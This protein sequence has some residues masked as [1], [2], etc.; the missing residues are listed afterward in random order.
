MGS[1]SQIERRRS[2]RFPLDSPVT[3]NTPDGVEHKCAARDISTGGIFFY[4]DGPF[5]QDSP[6]Q[7]VMILPAEITGGE[8][9]WAC[10]HGKVARVE[11]TPGGQRG[12]A[13]KIERIA[14]LPMA[15]A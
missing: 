4:C 1:T 7:L 9:Q 5:A 14:F 13:M 15:V 2:K 3:V 12:I 8:E 11:E 10:C 6:M